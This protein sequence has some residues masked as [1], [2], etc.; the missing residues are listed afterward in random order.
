MAKMKKGEKLVCIPCGTEVVISNSGLTE[1]T[2]WCCSKP[3]K[4]KAL[5]PKKTVKKAKR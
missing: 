3:M 5:A 4:K 1:S 2:L